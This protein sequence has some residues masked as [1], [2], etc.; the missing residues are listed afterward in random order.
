MKKQEEHIKTY[1]TLV[2]KSE[3][4]LST[5]LQYLESVLPK[6][7]EKENFI[8]CRDIEKL[9]KIYNDQ[10]F[11]L[12]TYS[13]RYV[14]KK[15]SEEE[16]IKELILNNN[17]KE[18]LELNK[19]KI[20]DNGV[21][22]DLEIMSARY[23]SLKHY[24]I[25]SNNIV[26]NLTRTLNELQKLDISKAAKYLIKHIKKVIPLINSIKDCQNNIW[27]YVE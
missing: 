27:L 3:F 19:E 20:F 21:N 6:Y 1:A 7:K 2:K 5:R 18:I 16:F 12:E 23:V 11:M 17:S 9:I 22:E 13:S 25:E 15:N 24:L 10:L 8:A 14:S 4:I 26:K